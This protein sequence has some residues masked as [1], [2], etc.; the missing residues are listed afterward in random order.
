RE[1]TKDG[2]W[3]VSDPLPPLAALPLTEGENRINNLPLVRGRRERSERGGRSSTISNRRLAPRFPHCHH[4]EQMTI[5][6]FEIEAA[7]T[8]AG[9]DLAVCVTERAA[10][11]R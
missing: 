7:T 3:C 2:R 11:I 8:T 1:I 9:I 4:F 6:I 5:G 10:A